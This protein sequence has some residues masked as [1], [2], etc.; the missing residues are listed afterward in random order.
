MVRLHWNFTL[1]RYIRNSPQKGSK[2][3][4]PFAACKQFCFQFNGIKLVLDKMKKHEFIPTNHLT[5]T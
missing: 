3:S 2:K 4:P 1:N 5:V